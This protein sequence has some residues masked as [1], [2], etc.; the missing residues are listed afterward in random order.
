MR[1]M[2]AQQA[3]PTDAMNIGSGAMELAPERF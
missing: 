2:G 3:R 1:L